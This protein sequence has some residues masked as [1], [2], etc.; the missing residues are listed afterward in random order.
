MNQFKNILSGISYQKC[1]QS[2]SNVVDFMSDRCFY[3]VNISNL[4]YEFKTLTNIFPD[5]GDEYVLF[6]IQGKNKVETR[7]AIMRPTSVKETYLKLYK[8]TPIWLIHGP[9]VYNGANRDDITNEVWLRTLNTKK[10]KR[11]LRDFVLRL[12]RY[13]N[14]IERKNWKDLNISCHEGS[15]NMFDAGYEIKRRTFDNVFLPNADKELIKSSLDK[16]IRSRDWYIR[17]CI[18]YHFGIL[19]YGEPGTAKTVTAQAIAEYTKSKMV[20]MFG[21]DIQFLPEKIDLLR[22]RPS[23]DTYTV[24]VIEDVDCGLNDESSDKIEWKYGRGG[25]M[26]AFQKRTNSF[27]KILNCIDGIDAPDNM[28]YV[29][30]TNHIEQLDPALIRPGRCDIKIEMKGVTDETFREF[31]MF[32]YKEYPSRTVNISK[33]ITFAE[34]QTDVMRGYTITQL[35]DKLEGN[36]ENEST[37]ND[38]LTGYPEGSL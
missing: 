3:S 1:A 16:F 37:G 10:H 2:I 14:H 34:L 9:V 5:V 22:N 28:I 13:A 27:A 24:L 7:P 30:T 15:R 29:L 21:S 38:T 25:T 33:H 4:M 12:M 6:N 36:E 18:P 35:I 31:C 32:H 17:N 11:V 26:E 19:L 20:T 8:G 23:N